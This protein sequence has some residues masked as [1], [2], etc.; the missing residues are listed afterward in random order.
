MLLLL[1]LLCSAL[2]VLAT[3]SYKGQ[4]IVRLEAE[5]PAARAFIESAN[6]DVWERRYQ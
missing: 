1:L 3:G 4:K 6:L 2:A 5:T